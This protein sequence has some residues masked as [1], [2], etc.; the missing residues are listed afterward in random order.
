MSHN[1]IFEIPENL[2]EQVPI[3]LVRGAVLMP[4]AKLPIPILDAQALNMVT[5]ALH[6]HRMI[7]L[8][9]PL[10]SE[11]D[12]ED[13]KIELFNSGSLGYIIDISELEDS[14]RLFITLS[15]VSRF[16]IIEEVVNEE[17]KYRQALVSYDKY[18]GDL[19]E[20]A[21]FNFDR[22]R[23]IKALKGYFGSLD[24]Q[25]NWEEIEQ[26]SNEKLITI[27]A[28]ACPFEVNERQALLE[29][30]TLKHQSELIT[31]LIE[32]ATVESSFYGQNQQLTKPH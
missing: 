7:G 13:S 30:P 24:V 3:L 25:P 31:F 26:T 29:S 6:G 23:L 15:G 11:F 17:K 9:Q 12:K 20:Q 8:V 14:N 5:D 28:M 2:P 18:K 4:R 16:D 1:F 21:D 27:L 10:T 19:V 32:M 22:P